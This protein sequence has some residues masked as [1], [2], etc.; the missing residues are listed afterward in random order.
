MLEKL[1]Q[2]AE[3]IS[4]SSTDEMM[5]M[6]DALWTKVCAETDTTSVFIKIWRLWAL[7]SDASEDHLVNQKLLSLVGD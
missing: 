3:S 4:L 1:Q 5:K 7:N 6:F 2:N